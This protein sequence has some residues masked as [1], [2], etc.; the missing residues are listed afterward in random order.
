MHTIK[1]VLL[2]LHVYW[3]ICVSL[4]LYDGTSAEFEILAMTYDW[5]ADT[6]YVAVRR[7]EED[8]ETNDKRLIILRIRVPDGQ[9]R[10]ALFNLSAFRGSQDIQMTIDP[11]RGYL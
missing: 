1:S 7:D 4:Q 5:I 10:V 2:I 3:N 8:E 9:V 6:L 11:L